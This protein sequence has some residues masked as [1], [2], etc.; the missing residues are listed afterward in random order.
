MRVSNSIIPPPEQPH[1]RPQV[2]LPAIPEQARA[3]GKRSADRELDNHPHPQLHHVSHKG[4][5]SR[6]RRVLMMSYHLTYN[7]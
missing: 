5:P 6:F 3:E 1:T 4:A 7:F 2:P